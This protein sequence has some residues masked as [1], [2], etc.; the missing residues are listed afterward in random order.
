[1]HKIENFGGLGVWGLAAL[2]QLLATMGIMAGINMM[3]WGYVV[4]YVG[5]LVNV[6]A[7]VVGYMAYDQFFKQS[8]LATPNGTSAAYMALMEREM[9]NHAASHIA[10]HFEMYHYAKDWVWGAY[11]NSSDEEKAAYREDKKFLMMLHLTPEMVEDMG[12]NGDKDMDMDKDKKMMD[13]PPALI[14][15]FVNI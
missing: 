7:M 6:A 3:V 9:A 11:M 1:M 15:S 2:T 10:G 12:M 5:G 8:E 14:M 4:G 13:G